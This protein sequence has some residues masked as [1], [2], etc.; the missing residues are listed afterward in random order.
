MHVLHTFY[1]LIPVQEVPHL[2]D[3]RECKRART[4]EEMLR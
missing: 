3:Q 4:H 1:E 2:V